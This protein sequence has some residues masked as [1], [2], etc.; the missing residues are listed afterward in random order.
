MED[1]S[2]RGFISVGQFSL[3]ITSDLLVIEE[4]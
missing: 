2:A 3:Q 4:V 1:L